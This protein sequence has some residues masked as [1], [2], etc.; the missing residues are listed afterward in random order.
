VTSKVQG[1]CALAPLPRSS[2]RATDEGNRAVVVSGSADRSKWSPLQ[3][4]GDKSEHPVSQCTHQL[5]NKRKIRPISMEG[6]G[7]N[8]HRPN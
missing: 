5:S 2:L 3:S 1:D 7:R 4:H 6:K 8:E